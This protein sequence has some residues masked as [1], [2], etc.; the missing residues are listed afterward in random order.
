M[1]A[2]VAPCQSDK[3]M[4]T[5]HGIFTSS[6]KT[7]YAFGPVL[8][9]LQPCSTAA[10]LACVFGRQRQLAK[11]APSH[12]PVEMANPAEGTVSVECRVTSAAAQDREP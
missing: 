4:S 5:L 8:A 1:V 11:G 2:P 9:I 7:L 6:K 10:E 3:L 12:F